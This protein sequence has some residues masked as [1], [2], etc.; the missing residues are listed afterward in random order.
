VIRLFVAASVVLCVGCDSSSVETGASTSGAASGSTQASTT[1]ASS[2]AA[3]TGT[4]SGASGTIT[5]TTGAGT[6]SGASGG[7]TSGSCP[8]S[9]SLEPNPIVFSDVPAGSQGSQTVTVQNDGCATVDVS[10]ISLGSLGGSC[11]TGSSRFS[12]SALPSFPDLLSPGDT[13]TFTLSYSASSGA[14]S[15][16][17]SVAYAA[18]S[19]GSSGTQTATDQIFGNQPG[20]TPCTL[21]LSPMALSFGAVMTGVSATRSVTLTNSGDIDCAVSNVE[22]DPISDPSF[23]LDP[24]QAMSFTVLAG[25]GAT[26]AVD[27]NLSNSSTPSERSG[28]VDFSSNDPSNA[29][30]SVPLVAFIEPP[31][32]Y[33]G[34]WPK[35]HADSNNSGFST[36]DTSAN[37]GALV[38]KYSALASAVG[39]N[40]DGGSANCGG[41]TYLGS[42][43]VTNISSGGY[44]VY[45][46][47]LDG[48]LFAL[49]RDGNLLWKTPTSAPTQAPHPSTPTVDKTGTIW[50]TSGAY[51]DAGSSDNLLLIGPNGTPLSETHYGQGGFAACPTLSADGLLFEA[52]PNQTNVGGGDPYSA[53][54]FTEGAQDAVSLST[55][56]AL[57]LSAQSERFGIA[58]G[59]D[60]TSYWANNGQFFAIAPPASGFMIS[61]SWPSTGVTTTSNLDDTNAVG[62]VFSDLAFDPYATGFIFAYSAWEDGVSSNGGYYANGTSIGPYTVQGQLVALAA[63]TG[64]IQWTLDLPATALPPGWNHLCSDYG[65]AAP[66][67]NVDGTVYVGNGDG[68]RAVDGATG[69]VKWLF[70]SANVSSA[71]AIGGDGT[72]FFGCQDGSFYAVN[73]NGSQRYH[74]QT[75]APV[76]A[77]PAIGPDGTVFFVSDDGTLWAVR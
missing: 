29:T 50:V 64:A 68:L 53:M 8:A 16:T 28:A 36:A 40:A 66:A 27:F 6:T 39:F 55:G 34:G 56:L 19:G 17:L 76:S 74:L 42:P 48:N 73:S 15:D 20:L 37:S 41:E 21:T 14:D 26:I 10:C 75:S 12:F 3:T 71:P 11:S 62:P 9:L 1:G 30:V 63:T 32:D 25:G 33:I 47:S 70:P 52:D 2:S 58:V 49:D 46:L 4:T 5:G 13:A 24:S 57:P 45:Q 31:S 35:W 23:M 65:N 22:I 18:V 59:P 61:A 51:P 77:S 7:A 60:D 67:V 69:L 38:W 43:V 44:T 72:V 54:T